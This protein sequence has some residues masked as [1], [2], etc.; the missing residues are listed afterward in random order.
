MSATSE[1]DIV[2]FYKGKNVLI[3]GGSGFLG[4]TVLWKLLTTCKQ[5]GKIYVLIRPKNNTTPQ[6]R[7]AQMIK[8]QP[9][10][11]GLDYEECCSKLVAIESDITV[12]SLGL[13][14][15]DRRELVDKVHVVI[16]TAASVKFDAPLKDNLRDNVYG[17]VSI[18]ELCDE[19]RNLKAFVHVGT[20][21]SNCHLDEVNEQIVPLQ[22]DVDDIVKHIES[23]S[24][25][26]CARQL[27]AL[28]EGRPNTYTY[29]KA[30]AEMYVARSEGKY[31]ISIVRPSIVIPSY[32]E[33]KPGWVDG[34]NGI[35]GLGC[36]A[37]I[38][39]LRTIDWNYYATSDMVPVDY[40]ANCV[41][42]SAYQ[43][44]A[45]S[46]RNII[47]YN[48]T[49]G[50]LCPMKWGAFFRLLRDDAHKKPST[51]IIRPMIHPPKFTRANPLVFFIIRFFSELLFAHTVDLLLTLF[52]QK[53]ILV[54]ITKK[55]HH[56]YKILLPFTTR[57]WNFHTRNVI[58][59]SESMSPC[60]KNVFKFDMKDFDW[61]RQ[62]VCVWHGGRTYLL[63]EEPTEESYK[64]ARSRQRLVTMVH[65][66]CLYAMAAATAAISYVL[67]APMVF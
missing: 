30:I 37:A 32:E 10:N 58:T 66:G 15:R 20:A 46:P 57:E 48:M 63:K 4:K 64:I 55:M 7:L 25:D 43:A 53:K 56:G 18:V 65:Y 31:P 41:I 24:E 13:S 22:R 11:Y 52:G 44:Y 2:N 26:E 49:S 59:M 36:L 3:T 61:Q 33:P 27:P 17:T 29:T 47:V 28:L 5:I 14:D 34:V 38:G 45:K 40:V 62:A 42:A 54:K 39:M 60:D 23:L 6:E 21:Y 35:C 9:F 51:R 8:K 1:S 16:H 12:K 19:I 50:S 67:I